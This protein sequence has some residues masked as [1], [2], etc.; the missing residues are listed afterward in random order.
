[1]QCTALTRQSLA[2][3]GQCS[4]GLTQDFNPQDLAFAEDDNGNRHVFV[5]DNANN[6]VYRLNRQHGGRPLVCDERR[7]YSRSLPG[8]VTA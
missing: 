4:H 2:G 6:K 5:T 1:M 8:Q 3:L 7:R